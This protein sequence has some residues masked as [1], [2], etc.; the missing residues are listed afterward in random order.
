[1]DN[2]NVGG[3]RGT[4]AGEPDVFGSPESFE[5]AFGVEKRSGNEQIGAQGG[6]YDDKQRK[7]QMMGLGGAAV[8]SN[9]IDSVEAE[10][11]EIGRKGKMDRATGGMTD[12]TGGM[13]GVEN[14]DTITFSGVDMETGMKKTPEMEPLAADGSTEGKLG[15]I[16][17]SLVGDGISRDMAKEIKEEYEKNANDPYEMA[18]GV[19]ELTTKFLKDAYGRNFPDNDGDIA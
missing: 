11:A 14:S 12:E 2:T 15:K 17:V 7:E 3:N 9:G 19:N 6:E 18:I 16:A 1:M 13:I 4:I 10:L 5:K 8:G